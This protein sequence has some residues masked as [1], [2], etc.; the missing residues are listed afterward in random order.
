M[1]DALVTWVLSAVQGA[2]SDPTILVN[3]VEPKQKTLTD[4]VLG[5]VGLTGVLV[6]LALIFALAFAAL[7][8]YVRS[9][10]PLKNA[11]EGSERP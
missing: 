4:V 9:R 7:L 6:G 11:S 10:N 3:L 5:A 1:T 2:Q 8:F